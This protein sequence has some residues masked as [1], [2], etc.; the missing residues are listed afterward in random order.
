[1][2]DEAPDAGRGASCIRDGLGADGGA[3]SCGGAAARLRHG[4]FAA[5][6]VPRG[7]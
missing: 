4:A 6:A 7:N 5:R 1:M 2:V 3:Q